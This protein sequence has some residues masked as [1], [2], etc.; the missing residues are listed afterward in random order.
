MCMFTGLRSFSNPLH[1]V[2]QEGLV[3]EIEIEGE[4]VREI[5]CESVA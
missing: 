5:E 3:I 4:F 2:T 1:G